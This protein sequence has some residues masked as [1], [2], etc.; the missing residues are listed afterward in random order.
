MTSRERV[1][2]VF[3]GEI[4]DRIPRW[5]GASPEFWEK[6]KKETNLNDEDLRIRMGDD[7]RRIFA[8]YKGPE[9]ELVEGAT[10][11]SP[12]GILREG[13]GYGQPLT[14]PL[15]D[16][17]NISAIEAWQW[18]DPMDVDVSTLRKQAAVWNGQ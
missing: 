7:F 11:C 5:C 10:W 14:H 8:R 13:I 18:P 1:A 16:A 2:A 4:P 9:V 3:A 17:E 6:A 15:K 12:F